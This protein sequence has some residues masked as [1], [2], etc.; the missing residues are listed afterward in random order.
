MKNIIAISITNR[1][2]P[3][4]IRKSLSFTKRRQVEILRELTAGPADE[5]AVIS[6]C[7][8]TEF[9]IVSGSDNE[10]VLLD[11]VCELA[12]CRVEKYLNIYKN[13]DAVRHLFMI[14]PGLESMV[15]G[16]DQILGQV[17][18]AIELA[19]ENKSAGIYLNTLFRLA[20]TAAKKVK[21]NTKLSEI[22]VSVATIA[23]KACMEELG[24][25]NG[26]KILLIGATGQLGK[27]ILKDIISAADAEI[28]AVLR[29][30]MPAD[31]ASYKDCELVDY[32]RRYKY[33]DSADCIISAT[34]S[35]HYT[36]TSDR[37]RENIKNRKKR[38]FIDLAV[39]SDIEP[40]DDTDCVYYS[41][42]TLERL[43]EENNRRKM[44]EAKKAEAML[45]E[46][47]DEFETWQIFF[48]NRGII[49][50]LCE[51]CGESFKQ[52]MFSIKSEKNPEKFRHFIENAFYML[53]GELTE[54]AEVKR[55]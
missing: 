15:I 51:A 11:Y 50:Q 1:N 23:V 49:W 25:L 22:P 21:T 8:R 2:A 44:K 7:N 36:L 30:R 48:E 55:K 28:Y 40:C 6:T 33:I 34:S 3:V 27:I 45:P 46:Y 19:R 18:S 26:K 35:P 4:E 12:Q 43:A 47:I 39:P 5:A 24:T 41:I 17:K 20:V 31:E 42:D 38:V 9:Y 10:K 32:A 37:I 13:D 53:S 14:A 54:L 29:S 52:R 16:E